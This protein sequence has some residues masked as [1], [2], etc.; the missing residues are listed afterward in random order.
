MEPRSFGITHGTTGRAWNHAQHRIGLPIPGF[1]HTEPAYHAG[2]TSFPH[3][4]P[5]YHAGTTS[6]PHHGPSYHF[7]IPGFGTP[8]AA[9]RAFTKRDSPHPH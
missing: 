8:E 5:A 1:P 6:F 2:T 4:E 7:C 9:Q 3:T